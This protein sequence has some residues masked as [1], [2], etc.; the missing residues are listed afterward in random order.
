MG[1]EYNNGVTMQRKVRLTAYCP[2][3]I[4]KVSL[5]PDPH[6]NPNEVQMVVG[7][8]DEDVP[9]MRIYKRTANNQLKK[10]YVHQVESSITDIGWIQHNAMLACQSNGK[11]SLF[12]V[13]TT[14]PTLTESY[15]NRMSEVYEWETATSRIAALSVFGYASIGED[16]FVTATD[17]GK[18]C[19]FSPND[20]PPMRTYK[21]E[22][23]V[24]TCEAL[25]TGHI[26]VGNEFGQA[27]I[28]DPRSN[29]VDP[30]QILDVGEPA[31]SVLSIAQHPGRTHLIL[32]GCSDGNLTLWDVRKGTD[33]LL[34]VARHE[35]AILDTKFHPHHSIAMTAGSDSKIL[36]Q[37][38]QWDPE[39]IQ[40]AEAMDMSAENTLEAINSISMQGDHWAAGGDDAMLISDIFR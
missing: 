19:I 29:T 37:N 39:K 11:T 38:G 40:E 30:V 3:R 27:K 36:L 32:G 7:S 33:E 12:R 6:P 20:K 10:D 18:I 23:A 31:I 15:N 28:F 17:S 35:G 22:C 34:V 14:H 25:S 2:F 5:I 9:E 26:L 13:G 8:L 16:A 1:F 4:S 21:D 24:K